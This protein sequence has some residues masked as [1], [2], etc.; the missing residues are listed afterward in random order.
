MLNLLLATHDDEVIQKID[1][2]EQ[3][4]TELVYQNQDIWL[5]DVVF[6]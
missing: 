3:K 5:R 1:Q 2:I 4:F 6:T